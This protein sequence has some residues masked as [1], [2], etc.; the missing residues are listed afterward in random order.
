[1]CG[2]YFDVLRG[3]GLPFGQCA[4]TSTTLLSAACKDVGRRLQAFCD[5]QVNRVRYF[6]VASPIQGFDCGEIR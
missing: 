1:M 5:A 4:V 2:H 3:V 6:I